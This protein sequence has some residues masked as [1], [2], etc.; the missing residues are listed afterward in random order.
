[1]QTLPHEWQLFLSELVSTQVPL[2]NVPL[3]QV[4]LELTQ[5]WPLAHLMVQP[6]Q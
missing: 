6:P 2:Q 1:M 5:L 3:V 4:Q